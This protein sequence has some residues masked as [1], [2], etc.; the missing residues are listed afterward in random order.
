MKLTVVFDNNAFDPR[1]RTGW[2]F[3][4]W[5]AYEGHTV[6]FDTGTNGSILL[7]NL[8]A[9]GFD[10]EAVEIVVLSHMHLDHTGGLAS[11]LAANPNVTVY[12]PQGFPNYFQEKVRGAGATVVEVA[13]PAEILPG[14][15][16]AGA[17]GTGIVE[18]AL[19]ARREGGLLVV[20]GCAHPGVDEMVARAT[21][22]GQDGIALVVGGFHLGS[23][24]QG[25]IKS[26]VD[27]FRRLGV[28]QVAPCHCTGDG[29]RVVFQQAY[30][31]D[32]Y[33]CGVGWQWGE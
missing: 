26:I 32:Y 30:G 33:P 11:L 10:P 31:P 25:R 6:L 3:A 1:L 4:A 21:D 8:A 17:M 9:L 7:G 18:Q 15:W 24:T 2:G 16:S 5:V 23:A 28:R 14:L 12:L 27:A 19:V 29:A 20:T 22:V 13:G